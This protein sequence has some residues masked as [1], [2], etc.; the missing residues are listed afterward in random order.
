MDPAEP[1]PRSRSVPIRVLLSCCILLGLRSVGSMASFTAGSTTNPG[2]IT[3]AQ[4]DV[5][6]NGQLATV[7][8][9][10]GTHVEA[11]WRIVDLLPGEYPAVLLTATNS[12]SMPLDLRMDAYAT[13]TLGPH[14][15]VQL[16]AGGTP[17]LPMPQQVLTASTWRQAT[18][19]G[20]NRLTAWRALGT[21][22]APTGLVTTK[23]RLNVGQSVTYCALTA[24]SGATVT[25]ENT[26]LINQSGSVV[27]LFRGTQV[28]AP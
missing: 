24:F 7:A 12:G 23:L 16:Y 21:E 20:G 3:S 14:L 22:A 5:V 17:S 8:D 15:D 4:L 28:G 11:T 13:G 6:L 26:S 25:Y 27:F 18:C 19:A 10:D 1:R 9:L 2:P